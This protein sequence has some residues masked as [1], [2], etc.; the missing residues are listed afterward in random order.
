MGGLGET[1]VPLS[2]TV[3][4]CRT[5][6]TTAL[7]SVSAGALRRLHTDACRTG[8]ELVSQLSHWEPRNHARQK[9][10]GVTAETGQVRRPAISNRHP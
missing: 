4:E 8:M 10:S 1:V 5:A 6:H 7:I 9:A 3:P 2:S